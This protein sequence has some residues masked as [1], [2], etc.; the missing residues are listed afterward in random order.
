MLT[1]V[2]TVTIAP[3]HT[4]FPIRTGAPSAPPN[5]IGAPVRGRKVIRVPNRDKLSDQTVVSNG[6]T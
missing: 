3:S 1:P 2:N 4:S 5:L 6:H